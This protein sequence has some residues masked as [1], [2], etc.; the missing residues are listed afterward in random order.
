MNVLKFLFAFVLAVCVL[1]SVTG[2][3]TTNSQSITW[4]ADYTKTGCAEC[5][6]PVIQ[7]M[8]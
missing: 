3:G 2:C 8:F 5:L 1:A 6:V 4:G 7:W